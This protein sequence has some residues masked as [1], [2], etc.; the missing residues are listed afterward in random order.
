MGYMYSGLTCHHFPGKG[1]F[2][3]VTG[4]KLA[5]LRVGNG[6]AAMLQLIENAVK[7]PQ[8]S[9]RRKRKHSTELPAQLA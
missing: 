9:V 5:A 3:K 2:L 7:F 4:E 6:V 8:L 1:I